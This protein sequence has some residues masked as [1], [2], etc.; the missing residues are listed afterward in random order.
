METF[1]AD[2]VKYINQLLAVSRGK[3]QLDDIR[4]DYNNYASFEIFKSVNKTLQEVISGKKEISEIRDNYYKPII[5]YVLNEIIK[6]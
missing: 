5:Q 4:N 3:R 6:D 2:A 1:D